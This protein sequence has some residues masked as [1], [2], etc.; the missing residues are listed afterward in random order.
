[1]SINGGIWK[2]LRIL[3]TWESAR[4]QHT[5]NNSLPNG[6]TLELNAYFPSDLEH[7]FKNFHFT[8]DADANIDDNCKTDD[9]RHGWINGQQVFSPPADAIPRL[10]SSINFSSSE[11][12]P[13]VS[14][15]TRLIIRRRLRRSLFPGSLDFLLGMLNAVEHLVYE[16]LRQWEN[17]STEMHDRCK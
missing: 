15:I 9:P 1:M 4:Q 2:L 5:A 6:I 17:R 13:S 8:S 16:P 3:G 11:K 14:S 12:I 10:F 7:W